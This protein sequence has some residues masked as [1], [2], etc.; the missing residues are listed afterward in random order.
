MRIQLGQRVRDS[1]SGF[2]GIVVCRAEWLNG[3]VRF[4]VQ[5]RVDKDGKLPEMQWID[6]G[7][8]EAMAEPPAENP[9]AQ[10]RKGGPRNDP[11]RSF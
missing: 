7:Q 10:P 4:S 2:E 9:V 5:P 3:C 8:C 11:V 1:V 6:E